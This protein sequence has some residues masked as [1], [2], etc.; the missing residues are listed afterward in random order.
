[1]PNT[2]AI[3]ICVG[4]APRTVVTHQLQVAA[5][6]TLQQALDS[7]PE[8]A[9]WVADYTPSVWGR[10]AELSQA[11]REQD[12]IELSRGLLVDPKVARRE[13]FASQGARMGGLF[14]RRRPGAKPG[15]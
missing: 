1:M 12:R 5:G 7:V 13:R 9:G 15:Y 3:E 14:A 10:K 8:L 2:I 4:T 6:T 11:L